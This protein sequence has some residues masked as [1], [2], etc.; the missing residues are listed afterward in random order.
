[1]VK[2]FIMCISI[3]FTCTLFIYNTNYSSQTL[4]AEPEE[5]YSIMC[6]K[7]FNDQIIEIKVWVSNFDPKKHKMQ[8]KGDGTLIIDGIKPIGVPEGSL[9]GS[10]KSKFLI[11]W[12]EKTFEMPFD[13]RNGCSGISVG[14]MKI[15]PSHDG[16]SVLIS[17]SGSDGAYAYIVY[18]TVV[19]YKVLER[20][21]DALDDQ[22]LP[23]DL[24]QKCN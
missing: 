6:S 9:P 5:P 12:N 23:E 13:L 1:M 14:G 3:N 4:A 24:Q 10:E 22:W 20:Y 15:F 21:V 19:K 18:W 2:Y 8:K 7:K 16:E 17:M 11:K